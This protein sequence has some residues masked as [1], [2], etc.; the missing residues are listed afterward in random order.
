MRTI[1][2]RRIECRYATSA[3]LTVLTVVTTVLAVCW[4]RRRKPVIGEETA[5]RDAEPEYD[6]VDESSLESFPAS[7]PPAWIR[8]HV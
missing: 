3:V 5:G 4:R 1:G 8:E 2:S 7:D 6:V